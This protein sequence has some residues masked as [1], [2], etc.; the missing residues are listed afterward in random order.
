MIVSEDTY[1][2]ISFVLEP[3]PGQEN[4]ATSH[5]AKFEQSSGK[6]SVQLPAAKYRTM[7]V[8]ALPSKKSSKLNSPSK[9]VKSEKIH[10]L[11]SDQELDIEISSKK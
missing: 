5:S 3:E 10:E 4:N 1:V 7:V 9:P 11:T 6:Y 2:T 8:I